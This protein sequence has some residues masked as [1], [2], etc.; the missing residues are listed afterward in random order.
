VRLLVELN[1][2]AQSAIDAI[3]C[4]RRGAIETRNQELHVRGARRLEISKKLE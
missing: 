1:M 2:D 4:A 3:R